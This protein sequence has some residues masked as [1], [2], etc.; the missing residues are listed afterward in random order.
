[1]CYKLRKHED[2]IGENLGEETLGRQASRPRRRCRILGDYPSY[3]QIAQRYLVSANERKASGLDSRGA[4]RDSELSDSTQVH[5]DR[6]LDGSLVAEANVE[7][8]DR[9]S[10][11]RPRP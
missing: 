7:R 11:Q 5:K 2:S 6:A 9:A 8:V 10:A 1:M 3:V 4:A